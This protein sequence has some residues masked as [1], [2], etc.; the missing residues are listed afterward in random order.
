MLNLEKECSSLYVF[1]DNRNDFGLDLLFS[2]LSC[3]YHVTN[4]L[5]FCRVKS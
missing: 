2:L 5:K 3:A 1:I 4:L